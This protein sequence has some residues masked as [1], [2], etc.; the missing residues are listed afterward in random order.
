MHI[1][2]YQPNKQQIKMNRKVIF[3]ATTLALANIFISVANT[4]FVSYAT[5]FAPKRYSSG[6]QNWQI[7]E[8]KD[9]V[10]YFANNNGLLVKQGES[11]ATIKSPIP[12][13]SI[14]RCV[15]IVGPK[16]Y[17]GGGS[18]FGYFIKSKEGEYKY[19]DLAM[20]VS[21]FTW[22]EA[23]HIIPL[24]DRVYVQGGKGI[25][26][27]DAQSDELIATIASRDISYLRVSRNDELLIYKENG[28]FYLSRD[29]KMLT[30]IED[31]E[32]LINKTIRS[33]FLDENSQIISTLSNGIYII[34]KEGIQE[35]TKPINKILIRD[36]IYC[37]TELNNDQYAFGTILNGIYITDHEFNIVEHIN[38]T[39]GL[40]NN[41][42][43][44]LHVDKWNNLWAGLDYGLSYIEVGS[45]MCK[46]AFNNN[47]G[48]AYRSLMTPKYRYWATN[49]GLFYTEE[50]SDNAR[51]VSGMQGQVWSLD[52]IGNNIVCQHHNGLFL[53]DGT[54]STCLSSDRGF[55][56]MRR[57]NDH[58]NY[59]VST[60]YANNYLFYLDPHSGTLEQ[61]LTFSNNRDIVN[62]FIQD[63]DKI[64]F[65]TTKGFSSA[66][67]DSLTA[68]I[69]NKVDY[70]CEANSRII[71][72]FRN[73]I[74]FEI[75][76]Q[77]YT[78]NELSGRFDPI[79]EVVCT[80]SDI[81]DLINIF[82]K[83]EVSNNDLFKWFGS[84]ESYLRPFIEIRQSLNNTN[85]TLLEDKVIF[86][87]AEGFVLYDPMRHNAP[88]QNNSLEII[89][90][91]AT[92]KRD[93]IYEYI[94]QR[95]LPYKHNNIRFKFFS[96]DNRS[97]ANI[98][99][100]Y[101][102]HGLDDEY[103]EFTT[104]SSKEY[105][106]LHEGN[107]RFE[108]LCKNDGE[109]SEPIKYTFKVEPPFSRSTTAK[110]LYALLFLLIVYCLIL[111]F[112][113]VIKQKEIK[114]QREKQISLH[115]IE[116]SHKIE[117]LNKEKRIIV[118][119]KEQ[120]EN[121]VHHKL[122]EL[123]NSTHNVIVKNELL[124]N[125][126]EELEKIYKER[127]TILRD[128]ALKSIF[129]KISANLNN[130][131]DWE[132]F[133]GSFSEIHHNFFKNLKSKY[134]TLSPNELKLCAYLRLNKSSKEIAALMNISNRGVETARYR[135]R[136]KL[137]V[138]RDDNIHDIFISM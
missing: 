41:T 54:K 118:M 44:S 8:D 59:Y 111:F 67:I 26:A 69:I 71:H 66:S 30:P 107:Y 24:Q 132:I 70:R 5:N 75:S 89:I 119:E 80:E 81:I 136:K 114:L 12:F 78:L 61:K 48:T 130:E 131:R 50:N 64:W 11:W 100:Q 33:V 105:T 49:Q 45:P 42:I 116:Q 87:G 95:I 84:S 51:L 6:T 57:I 94:S 25:M 13:S 120:L 36:Q 63:K 40:N 65:K 20:K 126:K 16:I 110:A 90:S 88:I 138:D 103:S 133:E 28:V 128:K 104:E 27:F 10:I 34:T 47:I 1:F 97:Q 68:K 4:S 115:R 86:N 127:D 124:I 32:T 123:T 79:S 82:I 73:Q 29:L 134:P 101:K 122:Q 137:G 93:N 35:C 56:R 96:N 121:A 19:T 21:N 113:R 7:D 117:L 112:R 91:E 17:V 31:G 15:K 22:G 99:Y 72:K 74:I 108:V 52:M 135:L 23:W 129:N 125:I 43:L 14:L 39:N 85:I 2:V 109:I 38:T 77:L 55:T 76:G 58:S 46:I 3:L 62:D 60:S 37:A 83:T 18:Q 106:N 53:I 98:R 102:L 92:Y 9:G